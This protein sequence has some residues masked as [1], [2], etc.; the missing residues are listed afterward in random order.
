MSVAEAHQG[1][2][3]D[4]MAI[5]F[6]SLPPWGLEAD[7]LR[8]AAAPIQYPLACRLRLCARCG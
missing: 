2:Y 6:I 8:N 7:E 3:A 4:G 5:Q 1:W